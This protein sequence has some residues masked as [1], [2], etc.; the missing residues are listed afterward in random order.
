MTPSFPMKREMPG[1]SVSLFGGAQRFK[2]GYS[3]YHIFQHVF[4]YNDAAV[5]TPDEARIV[6]AAVFGSLGFKGASGRSYGLAC[7]FLF[8]QCNLSFRYF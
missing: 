5:E 2:F 8:F 4:H 6:V 7:G 3:Q 1:E